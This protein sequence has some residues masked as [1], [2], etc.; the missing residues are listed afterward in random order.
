M[1]DQLFGGG[2]LFGHTRFHDLNGVPQEISEPPS[3]RT[4]TP[5][6]LDA[7]D[8][9]VGTNTLTFVIYNEEFGFS[10]PSPTGLRVEGTPG[11]LG[12]PC[13]HAGD[14]R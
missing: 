1:L 4:M 14:A 12:W 8:F 13:R 2:L 5:F 9:V 10:H 6:Q 7:S 11:P 3:L